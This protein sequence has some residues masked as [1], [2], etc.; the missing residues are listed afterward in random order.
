MKAGLDPLLDD[1]DDRP[2]AKL[3]S[4]D[5]IG[6]PWQI[7]VGPRGMDNGVVE[8]KHRKSGETV[9][10]SPESALNKVLAKDI[11]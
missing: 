3:A 11:A 6:I 9:E 2:G 4:M 1:R 8:V 7:V 5:L 10:I